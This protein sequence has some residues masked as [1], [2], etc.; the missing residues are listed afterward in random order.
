MNKNDIKTFQMTM[1]DLESIKDNLIEEFDNFWDYNILK[2]ELS[3]S[4]SY[5]IVAKLNKNIVGFTGIKIIFDQA[6]LMNIV[7]KK[8][9]RNNR[10]CFPTFRKYYF[11]M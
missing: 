4:N 6:E 5:Y 1:I 9:M 7:T 11:Y 2:E 10:N 3:S 8:D